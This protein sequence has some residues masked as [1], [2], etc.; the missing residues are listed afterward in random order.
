MRIVNY[1]LPLYFIKTYEMKN[2]VLLIFCTC[3]MAGCKEKEQDPY[4]IVK[5]QVSTFAEAYFNY[6][7]ETAREFVASESE[8]WLRFAASNVLQDDIDL[9]N[10]RQ[11]PATVSVES[12]ERVN[13]STVLATVKVNNFMKKDSIGQAGTIVDE[14]LFKFLLV[15]RE[16]KYYV[17][18]EGLPRSERQSHD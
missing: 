5:Q 9:L 2:L 3:F 11:A 14:A 7:F 16:G 18:M 8:K 13:D 17:R 12:C 15:N 4:A 6:E 1:F 10:A